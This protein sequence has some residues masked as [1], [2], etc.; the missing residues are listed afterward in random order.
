[1]RTVEE[2]K[3]SYDLID[4]W[5]IRNIDKRQYTWRQ[6]KPF[7][8]RRLDFW[9]VSDCLQDVVEYTDIIPSIKSD[10]SAITLHIKSNESHAR[11]PSHWCFNSS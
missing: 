10:H 1:M 11:G 8:Q 5:R 9:L 7:V 3:F 6:R 2:L 4:I